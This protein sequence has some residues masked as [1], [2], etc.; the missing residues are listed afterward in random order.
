MPAGTLVSDAAPL[1]GPLAASAPA[2]EQHS[3]SQHPPFATPQGV[4]AQ[5][6]QTPQQPQQAVS[7]A[8]ASVWQAA[9]PRPQQ[10]EANMAQPGGPPRQQLVLLALAPA[11]GQSALLS[12]DILCSRSEMLQLKY[13]HA[14]AVEWIQE[15]HLSIDRF[16]GAVDL[17]HD[18]R[19]DWK[20][21]VASRPDVAE[22]IGAGIT[23]FEFRYLYTPDWEC[24]LF[25]RGDFVAHR[26][27]GTCVRLHPRPWGEVNPHT[28]VKEALPMY[29]RLEDWA[30]PEDQ[31]STVP[32][33]LAG[34]DRSWRTMK[35][36]GW[37]D[38]F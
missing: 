14:D 21:Y 16:V 3:A 27:D 2:E 36:G 18:E 26:A 22:V 6:A 30:P 23:K 38:H 34:T 11:Q 19:Y 10:L 1:A 13:R 32:D 7:V 33:S 24:R 5:T 17:S 12:T 4:A 8:E 37:E 20:R 35:S 29:G 25:F 15:L 9:D 28:N 31:E